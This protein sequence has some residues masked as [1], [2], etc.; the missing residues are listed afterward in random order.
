MDVEAHFLPNADKLAADRAGSALDLATSE[1]RA[2]GQKGR[3]S[4]KLTVPYAH[5][6]LKIGILPPWKNL[7]TVGRQGLETSHPLIGT[8][9]T[10]PKGSSQVA[11]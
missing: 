9:V 1:G 11:H 6:R 5:C 4:P 7:K 3:N 8:R 2:K 10:Q